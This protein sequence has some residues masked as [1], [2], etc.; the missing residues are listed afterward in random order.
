MSCLLLLVSINIKTC[1]S[2]AKYLWP[3]DNEMDH[4]AF[5]KNKTS[6]VSQEIFVTSIKCAPCGFRIQRLEFGWHSTES[7]D[8]ED[9]TSK[10]LSY[11]ITKGSYRNLVHNLVW[12]FVLMV[13]TLN[14]FKT[15]ETCQCKHWRYNTTCFFLEANTYKFLGWKPWIGVNTLNIFLIDE[16][17]PIKSN[18]KHFYNVYLELNS[19]SQYSTHNCCN[20]ECTL[21]LWYE[22]VA[23]ESNWQCVEANLNTIE[24]NTLYQNVIVWTIEWT[25]RIIRA[26]ALENDS[27]KRVW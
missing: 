26:F 10:T 8:Y 1:E 6:F 27:I 15:L 23:S 14:D 7:N 3:L 9:L 13:D 25:I 20:W 16:I 11:G 5:Y 18:A 12:K 22:C 21:R 17:W 19:D 2:N 4:I 24:C